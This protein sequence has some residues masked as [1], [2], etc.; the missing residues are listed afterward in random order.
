[1]TAIDFAAIKVGDK[2]KLR[3]N[4][5]ESVDWMDV[6]DNASGGFHVANE[7]YA[8]ENHSNRVHVIAH[9]PAPRK[10][11]VTLGEPLGVDKRKF[12]DREVTVSVSMCKY[13]SPVDISV[14]VNGFNGEK[15]STWLSPDEAR[16]LALDILA[17]VGVEE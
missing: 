3:Y 1:M 8:Y 10:V 9:Q 14:E 2:V 15:C 17:T 6:T 4:G 7:W 11:D 13:L 16:R 12:S 5:M